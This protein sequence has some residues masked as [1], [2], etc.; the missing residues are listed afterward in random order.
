MATFGSVIIYQGLQSH[1]V[2]KIE[3]TLQSF[4][5]GI[6]IFLTYQIYLPTRQSYIMICS[7]VDWG[8]NYNG[9]LHLKVFDSSVE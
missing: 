9:T 8:L 2:S 4:Q 5:R 3:S 1:L 7:G 6:P